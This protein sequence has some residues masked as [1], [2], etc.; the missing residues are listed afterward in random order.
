M[1]PAAPGN[2]ALVTWQEHEHR[3]ATASF[4]LQPEQIQESC[5][6]KLARWPEQVNVILFFAFSVTNLLIFFPQI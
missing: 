5:V 1:L 6:F 4:K 3:M 2:Y